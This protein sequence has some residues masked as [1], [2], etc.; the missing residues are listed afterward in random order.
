MAKSDNY[1]R[2]KASRIRAQIA[3]GNCSEAN[4]AWL[5]DYESKRKW[6]GGK[7]PPS[8]AYQAAREAFPPPQTRDIPAPPQTPAASFGGDAPASESTAPAGGAV[9]VPPLP[10]GGDIPSP[11][12]TPATPAAPA[13]PE[14]G[15]KLAGVTAVVEMAASAW[16]LA[17]AD[18]Q[19]RTEAAQPMFPDEF[20]EKLWK[21]AAI[22]LGVKYLP[23]SVGGD[24]SDAIMVVVP[25]GTTIYAI[26]KVSEAQAKENRMAKPMPQPVAPDD[27]DKADAPHAVPPAQGGTAS[28]LKMEIRRTK[29]PEMGKD[30]VY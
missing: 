17:L 7:Q 8:P 10:V 19:K 13:T 20:I 26:K 21:P 9:D 29:A 14:E 27:K 11:A 22:R 4:R 18:L 2:V 5:A 30:A 15:Q 3:R 12:V 28:D 16:K 24:L 6:S 25:P 1:P 23:D